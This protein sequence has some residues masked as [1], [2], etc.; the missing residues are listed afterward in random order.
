[1]SNLKFF[2]KTLKRNKEMRSQKKWKYSKNSYL[3]PGMV[4]HAFNST[5]LGGG[6]RK[7]MVLAQPTKD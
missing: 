3:R 6:N 2:I 1:M 7:I 5:Y 4:G